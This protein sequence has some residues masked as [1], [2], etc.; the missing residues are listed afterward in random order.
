MFFFLQNMTTVMVMVVMMRMEVVL[1][2]L[3]E[4]QVEAGQLQGENKE[5]N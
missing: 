2:T 3:L 1:L 5:K 4:M